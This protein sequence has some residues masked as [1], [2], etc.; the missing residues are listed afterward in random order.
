M[1]CG[2]VH[3]LFGRNHGR[4]ES[5]ALT[6]I[7]FGRCSHRSGD[8]YLYQVVPD[9][10]SCSSGKLQRAMIRRL[11]SL[12]NV[13]RLSFHDS[14]LSGEHPLGEVGV[15]LEA[16]AQCYLSLAPPSLRRKEW[17]EVLLCGLCEWPS[18]KGYGQKQPPEWIASPLADVR[19][20][21]IS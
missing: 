1:G 11:Q 16:S 9:T 7:V 6:P 10:D 2:Y 20:Q 4:P 8:W 19:L 3:F 15:L 12:D 21:A 5:S 13:P 14:D 17:K 18:D